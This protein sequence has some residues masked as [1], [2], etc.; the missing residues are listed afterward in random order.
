MSEKL[1]I[2]ILLLCDVFI[3]RVIRLSSPNL[4][5]ILIIG[6]AM[7]YMTGIVFVIPS[8]DP[9]VLPV[10]CIISSITFHRIAVNAMM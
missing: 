5:Y 2:I 9:L 7:V 6:V 10:F 3:C 4:N 1:L 8:N